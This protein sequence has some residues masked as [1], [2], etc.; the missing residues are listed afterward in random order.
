MRKLS[1]KGNV[2]CIKGIKGATVLEGLPAIKASE[3]VLGEQM[4]SVFLGTVRQFATLMFSTN[5]QPYSLKKYLDEIDQLMLKIKVPTTF[6]RLPR[7]V[8]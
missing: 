7:K 8:S 4:H 5:G 2:Q 6:H 3:S 1:G